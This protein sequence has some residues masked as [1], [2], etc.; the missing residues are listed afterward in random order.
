MFKINLMVSKCS[1]EHRKLN[2]HMFYF[3]NHK[4]RSGWT[5]IQDGRHFVLYVIYLGHDFSNRPHFNSKPQ[6]YE[7]YLSSGNPHFL[8]RCTKM[9]PSW[10]IDKSTMAYA[11]T[12]FGSL[13]NVEWWRSLYKIYIIIIIIMADIQIYKSY[14]SGTTTVLI[15][16]KNTTKFNDDLL[17]G[18]IH[19]VRRSYLFAFL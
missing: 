18:H 10:N 8:L 9:P 14:M 17:R 6:Y 15:L 1:L 11:I 2:K 12:F 4:L 13:S 16:I 3:F 7:N 19:L 5:E